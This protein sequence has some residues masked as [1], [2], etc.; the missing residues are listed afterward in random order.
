MKKTYYFKVAKNLDKGASYSIKEPEVPNDGAVKG[1][2][3]FSSAAPAKRWSATVVGRNRLTW[4]V[5]E[6]KKSMTSSLEVKA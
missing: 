6:D 2:A 4:V 3:A 5:S 1:C